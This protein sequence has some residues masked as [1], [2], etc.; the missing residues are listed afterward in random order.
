MPCLYL[1]P[2]VFS[3]H[4]HTFLHIGVSRQVYL[5]LHAVIHHNRI[6]HERISDFSISRNSCFEYD[7]VSFPS[8]L[9][10]V[11]VVVRNDL[12]ELIRF[13]DNGF[14]YSISGVTLPRYT[15]QFRQFPRS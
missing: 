3:L 4:D 8:Q 12:T 6:V 9:L 11:I 10:H 13:G 1:C 2:S 5:T 14:C 15:T 7:S